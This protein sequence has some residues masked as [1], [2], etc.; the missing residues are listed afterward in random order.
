MQ[1][2]YLSALR[3]EYANFGLSKEALDRVALQRV[4]TIANEDE[5]DADIAT[6]ATMLLVM[7]EMQ[8]SADALRS[9]AAV[10]QKELDA[11]KSVPQTV[12][13]EPSPEDNPLAKDV[14][15]MKQMFT[16]MMGKMAENERK[17][18]I[19]EILGSADAKMRE[20]GCT[21]DFIRGITLEKAEVGESDTAD[22]I[23]ERYK[24]AYD[25]NY[26]SAFGNG[27]VPPMSNGSGNGEADQ[28]EIT[29]MLQERGL[30]PK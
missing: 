2:K 1:N 14:A 21:N 9:K 24:A 12:V 27:Q 18:R 30:L 25:A 4:K 5:I 20:M 19:T 29:R 23:A 16:A 3:K 8:S 28:A 13:P 17:A 11:L 15:E 10:A 6:T 26:S 7:K 22:T